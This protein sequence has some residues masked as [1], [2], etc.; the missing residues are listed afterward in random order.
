MVRQIPIL[1]G[2]ALLC[3]GC[4]ADSADVRPPSEDFYFPTG[5]APSPDGET[6][7]VINAN[8]DLRFAAGSI[9]QVDVDEV[10]DIVTAWT[11]S[12]TVPDADECEQDVDLSFLLNCD[13]RLV[14]IKDSSVRL[15][16]FATNIGIQ[17]LDGGD[18]RLFV[19][20]RGD[21]SITFIDFS[22]SS[23]SLDC[24]G[25]GSQPQCDDDHRLTALRGDLDIGR[26]FEEPFSV[27][28][29]SVREYV[30][31]T[32]LTSGSVTLVDAP[33]NGGSPL[34]TDAI[35]GLFA[36]DPNTGAR[37]AVGIAGRRP[38]TDDDLVYV[39]SRSDSRIQ[40]LS[41]ARPGIDGLPRLAPG[42]FFFLD[43]VRPADDSR[44]IAFGQGGDRA[45]IVNRD[46]P[47]L[48][49]IDTSTGSDG[50]PVNRF[51][52]GVELCTGAA[53]L[54]VL[55]A[56]RGERVYVSCFRSGQVWA[57][58]PVGRV[59]EAVIN[60]GRGPNS[61]IGLVERGQL[62]VTNFLEDTISVIDI[63]P[64]SPFENRFV[65]RIGKTRQSEAE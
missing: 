10:D 30:M 47:L 24:G 39:T 7:F 19:A 57:I 34:I 32:H 62:W 5:L 43:E 6:V 42:D 37:G 50:S 21:P 14:T 63:E 28:V 25:S 27:F 9:V 51:V 11:E 33:S 60:V 59:V 48:H 17:E 20:S 23:R 15:A 61:L 65:F 29:D 31:V 3:A 36:S 41:M 56:G 53:N 46:P 49:V 45:Y 38:G 54:T 44:E 16:S 55:D 4:P 52:G 12:G 35:S 64:G 13:E 2:L 8:A 1:V 18:A 26:L 22:P 58:D 40:T